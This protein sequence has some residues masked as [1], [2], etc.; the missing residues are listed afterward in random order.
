M[1]FYLSAHGW[2]PMILDC[3]VRSKEAN[4][5]TTRPRK[6]IKNSSHTISTYLPGSNLAISAHRFPLFV[7]ASRIVRSSS[8]VH[9]SLHI[10]GFKWLCHRSRHCFPMRPGRW[11]AMRDH[12]L[13]PYCLTSS[14]TFVSSSAVQGPLTSSGFKTFCQ[15]C[16]H[17]TSVRFG[18]LWDNNFQF[19]APCS[20]T[21]RR[22]DSS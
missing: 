3:I 4:R 6:H 18:K 19:L 13:A 2:V 17:C 11:E 12:F 16:R 22:R 8:N 7:C 20:R 5:W 1:F 14:M 21:A 15:R 10:S 9:A